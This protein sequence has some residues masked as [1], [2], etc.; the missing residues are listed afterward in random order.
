MDEARK[1]AFSRRYL[2]VACTAANCFANVSL[3]LLPEV[4]SDSMEALKLT[5]FQA[6][7]VVSAET[8]MM[9]LAS[10]IL[11]T[12]DFR[13]SYRNLA[14][15]AAGVGLVGNVLSALAP[16]FSYLFIARAIAG[17][18]EGAVLMVA[19]SLV[20]DFEHAD[21][22]YA[23]MNTVNII[24]GSAVFFSLPILFPH[25][26]GLAVFLIVAIAMLPLVL[27]F[28]WLT[29]RPVHH[30]AHGV[31]ADDEKAP[32]NIFTAGTLGL[33]AGML[34]LGTGCGAS[35][36]F[37]V[38]FGKQVHMA[39]DQIDWAIS[40]STVSAIV[41]SAAVGVIGTRFGRLIPVLMMIAVAA[42]ANASIS[43]G[44]SPQ[45]FRWS[46][47]ALLIAIYFLLPYFLGFGAALDRSGRISAIVSSVF[48]VT[49]GSIGPLVAGLVADR[50]GIPAIGTVTASLC[51]LSA[52][53]ISFVAYRAARGDRPAA[54]NGQV[55][56]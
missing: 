17:A 42:V 19:T 33:I 45:V 38:E 40:A 13:V 25:R 37:L 35:W 9:A 56:A 46:A 28:F 52:V 2:L 16:D 29:E 5:A 44:N 50:T 20:A 12:R 39:Q 3:W 22:A 27:P 10:I 7:A 34:L 48:M 53:A 51:L 23:H 18:G 41:A 21:R 14:L 30:T 8:V 36:A 43:H 26:D 6:S 15:A 54:G 4:L 47:I 24:Y 11:S 1:A 31:I 32:A 49:S 55:A